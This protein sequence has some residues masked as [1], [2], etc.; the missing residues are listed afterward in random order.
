MDISSITIDSQF[1]SATGLLGTGTASVL[2]VLHTTT[3]ACWLNTQSSPPRGRE[4]HTFI[5]ESQ[6]V[7]YYEA[8]SISHLLMYELRQLLGLV[9]RGPT[10][11]I[12]LLAPTFMRS[13]PFVSGP[14]LLDPPH[15][16]DTKGFQSFL[17]TS[18][19]VQHSFQGF[20]TTRLDATDNIWILTCH[21]LDHIFEPDSTSTSHC[22][23]YT[24][25]ATAVASTPYVNHM[26]WAFDCPYAAYVRVDEEAQWELTLIVFP[27]GFEDQRGIIKEYAIPLPSC[28]D[29][30]LLY[31][32]DFDDSRGMLALSTTDSH[33]YIVELL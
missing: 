29:L 7:L 16:V 9:R 22:E 17:G 30:E 15:F 20:V 33:V 10:P 23:T 12:T 26:I 32:M 6:L 8:D 14:K 11:P 5:S 27:N 19:K 28:I 21:I 31:D 1:V 25:L 4:M 13:M 24:I 3:E 2:F 18:H